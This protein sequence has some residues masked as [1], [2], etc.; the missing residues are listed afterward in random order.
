MTVT[1]HARRMW[2]PRTAGDSVY[3]SGGDQSSKYIGIGIRCSPFGN[4]PMTGAHLVTADSVDGDAAHRREPLQLDIQQGLLHDIADD[5]EIHVN[6]SGG[7][8][9][10]SPHT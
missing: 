6:G 3:C 4:G 10:L 9:C 8:P 5:G 1:S 2:N 7:M